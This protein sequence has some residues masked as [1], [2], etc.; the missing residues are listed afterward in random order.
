MILMTRQYGRILEH[1]KLGRPQPELRMADER[2]A[3][4]PHTSLS[5]LTEKPRLSPAQKEIA[6]LYGHPTDSQPML[7]PAQQE[8]ARLYGYPTNPRR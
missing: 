7:S 3:E 6:R 5:V 4:R 2:Q 8:I 1:G